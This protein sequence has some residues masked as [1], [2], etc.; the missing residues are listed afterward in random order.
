MKTVA[1]HPRA[2][3][4][5][6]DYA[7]CLWDKLPDELSPHWPQDPT[8][9]LRP[10]AELQDHVVYMMSVP[11]LKDLC[12]ILDKLLECGQIYKCDTAF[13][14]P[15]Y[16]IKKKLAG[17]RLL[18]YMQQMNSMINDYLCLLPNIDALLDHCDRCKY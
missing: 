8:L 2:T 5:S 14:S 4:L 16:A 17:Y 11:E 12:E 1:A 9:E 15:A 6:T 18:V 10:Y 3:R 13:A 7:N